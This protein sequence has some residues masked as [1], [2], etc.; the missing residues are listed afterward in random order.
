MRYV[1][2]GPLG[3]RVLEGTKTTEIDHLDGECCK[4]STIMHMLLYFPQFLLL[5]ICHRPLSL[6]IVMANS[7]MSSGQLH[8]AHPIMPFQVQTLE[9][10]NIAAHTCL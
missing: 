4:H 2:V 6:L 9:G 3:P 8:V 1:R 7:H 5:C 10:V